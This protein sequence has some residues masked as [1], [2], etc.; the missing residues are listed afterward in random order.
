MIK[1]V[2]QSKFSR[3]EPVT[4]PQTGAQSFEIIDRDLYLVKDENERFMEFYKSSGNGMPEENRR[5]NIYPIL[6]I[7]GVGKIG[8]ILFDFYQGMLPKE[9]LAKHLTR[10]TPRD[11]MTANFDNPDFYKEAM[12]LETLDK[13]NFEDIDY[14]FMPFDN[15]I[16]LLDKLYDN[17]TIDYY[18]RVYIKNHQKIDIIKDLLEKSN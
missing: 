3:K 17:N 12:E 18:P 9:M 14:I 8:D 16:N 7:I 15:F 1:E 4:D 11:G 6:G 5:G 2:I 10:Y 13:Y